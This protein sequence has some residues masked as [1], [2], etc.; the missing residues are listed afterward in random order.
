M[1]S[2]N[3]SCGDLE[4]RTRNHFGQIFLLRGFLNPTRSF[5]NVMEGKV[6]WR[7]ER[8]RESGSFRPASRTVQS[9]R[10]LVECCIAGRLAAVAALAH[11]I[12][13]R[14]RQWLRRS[15][16][17]FEAHLTVT[18]LDR[19]VAFYQ[20]QL[21]L[22]LAKIFPERKVAFFG[23]VCSWKGDARTMGGGNHAAIE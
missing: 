20:D 8:V 11:L 12:L 2:I 1:R 15:C 14:L 7:R 10:L 17:L 16:D 3:M 18:N 23:S 22:P 21:A 19:A 5:A 9:V 6:Y 4:A 13:I